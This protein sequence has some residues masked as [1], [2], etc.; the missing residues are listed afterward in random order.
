MPY[1]EYLSD[2]EFLTLKGIVEQRVREIMD[3]AR[4]TV[5]EYTE[6]K[7]RDADPVD[8]ASNE[9]DLAFSKRINE[10]DRL[11]VA[12]YRR[13]QE[14]MNDREYGVCER[15]GDPIGYKRL[16]ARPVA[17]LCIDCKTTTEQMESPGRGRRE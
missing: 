15:C 9:T 5:S 4:R 2:D 13:A 14:R 1:D 17:T 6:V 12:K 16:L 3:Q 11:M 7:D 10:R 8:F